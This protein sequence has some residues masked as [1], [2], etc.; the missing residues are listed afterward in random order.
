[1]QYFVLKNIHI[2]I[3]T[4]LERHQS[5]SSFIWL[6]KHYTRIGIKQYTIPLENLR[7]TIKIGLSIRI[8]DFVKPNISKGSTKLGGNK[9]DCAN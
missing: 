6:T 9:S 2:L 7:K 8:L 3:Q 5:I 1:V 4:V